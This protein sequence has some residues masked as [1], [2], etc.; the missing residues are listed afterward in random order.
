MKSEV[1]VERI[2]TISA[3]VLPENLHRGRQCLPRELHLSGHTWTQRGT[4]C[5]LQ[6]PQE[7]LER[8]VLRKG[9]QCL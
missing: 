7:E 8:Q 9:K 5:L 3:P 2:L 6:P 1:P 4:G